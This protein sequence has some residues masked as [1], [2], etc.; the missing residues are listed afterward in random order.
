MH[1]YIHTNIYCNNQINAQILLSTYLQVMNRV[2][3][4]EVQKN[5]KVNEV[6]I[7]LGF[8]LSIY[9]T[10]CSLKSAAAFF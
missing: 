1:S 10:V 6:P 9:G 8:Y 5:P 7:D 3:I 4:G 2:E